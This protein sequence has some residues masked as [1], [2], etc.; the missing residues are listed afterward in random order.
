MGI[1]AVSALQVLKTG[2]KVKAYHHQPYIKTTLQS[3]ILMV[4]GS[5]LGLGGFDIYT[6]CVSLLWRT[7]RRMGCPSAPVSVPGL[8]FEAK[9][10]LLVERATAVKHF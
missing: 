1:Y 10:K 5:G 9:L 3:S 2:G 7:V 4:V 8:T 6:S